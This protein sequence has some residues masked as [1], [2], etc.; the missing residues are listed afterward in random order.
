LL[1]LLLLL[2]VGTIF[3]SPL[4]ILV[5]LVIPGVFLV[6]LALDATPFL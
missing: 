5:W 6:T 4:R 1:L 3:P 2:L